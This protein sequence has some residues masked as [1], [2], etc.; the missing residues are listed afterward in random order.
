MLLLFWL[1]YNLFFCVEGVSRQIHVFLHPKFSARIWYLQSS[2][3]ESAHSLWGMQWM[4]SSLLPQEKESKLFHFCV[5]PGHRKK[6]YFVPVS[7][8]FLW[9]LVNLVNILSFV[10]VKRV[11]RHMYLYLYIYAYRLGIYNWINIYPILYLVEIYL[12]ENI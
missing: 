10:L 8:T 2:D 3:R 7:R 4:W 11:Y 12:K 9:V 1:S 6:P 5:G